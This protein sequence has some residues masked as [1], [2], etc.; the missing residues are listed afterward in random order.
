MSGLNLSNAERPPL[1]DTQSLLRPNQMVELA[2]EVQ[3]LEDMLSAPPHVL[4]HV[5]V[6]AAQDHLRSLRK[7]LAEGAPRS[8][9]SSERDQAV[10]DEEMLRD[11]I[12]SGM[13]T[14]AEMRRNPAGAVDK[15]RMWERRSKDDIARWKHLR[16]RMY[17]SGMIDAPEDATDIANVEL[18][19]PSGGPQELNMHNE[20]IP[21]K[22]F[23]FPHQIGVANL[24]S[25]EEKDKLYQET[26]EILAAQ[27]AEGSIRAQDAL[28]RYVGED[29]AVK[30]MAKAAKPA[31]TPP[32]RS[33]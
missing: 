17:A 18:F 4:Q 3:R 20:Q 31:G 15:H 30:L 1:F 25:E 2:G 19:R 28:E 8:L 6:P 27:A 29:K 12:A 32:K 9:E 5:D 14:Q 16:L 13:P 10:R 26:I 11:K 21:G 23:Y 33:V 7:T 24:M 22:S